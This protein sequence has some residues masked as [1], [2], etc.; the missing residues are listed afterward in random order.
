MSDALSTGADTRGALRRAWPLLRPFLSQ[1]VVAAAFGVAATVAALLGPQALRIAIDDGILAGDRHTLR[2]GAFA[3]LLLAILAELCKWVFAILGSRAGERVLQALRIRV[4]SRLLGQPLRF[5]ESHGSGELLARNVNDVQLLTEFVRYTL[6]DVVNVLLLLSLGVFTLLL[7]AP[8]LAVVSLLALPLPLVA[9]RWYGHVSSPLYAKIAEADAAVTQ[10]ISEG[11]NGVDVTHATGRHRWVLGRLQKPTEAYLRDAKAGV[12]VENRV[13]PILEF[14]NHAA[15]AV[16]LVAGGLLLARDLVTVGTVV[17]CLAYL[18]LV[19][20]PLTS[21]GSLVSSVQEARVAL[22]R[23][24][25][26]DELPPPSGGSRDVPAKGAL[27]V[28]DV[29]F[30]YDSRATVLSGVSLRAKPGQRVALAGRTGAGK[31]TLSRIMAGL[32]PPDEGH[33]LVG[34]IDVRDL[35]VRARRET[36]VLL[37]QGNHI[38]AGTIAENL[39]AAAREASDKDLEAAFA[40]LGLGDFLARLPDGLTTQVGRGGQLLSSGERQ[41]LG[42]VR[43]A[44]RDPAVIVLD[45]STSLVDPETEAVL[46]EPLARL[47][48]DCVLIIVAHRPSTLAA[49]DVVLHLKDGQISVAT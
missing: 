19:V 28:V 42:L 15:I 13:F 12:R 41:L 4:S 27:E 17:A 8:S 32:Y 36:V 30:G 5:F 35:T 1:L 43:V 7:T 31:T 37:P 21:I 23:L 25:S 10:R 18:R 3:F 20:E 14:N 46:R 2:S 9:L 26:I 47:T 33:V 16:V 40:R 38:F 6:A 44:L 22:A 24:L 48:R 29:R 34:G 39:R 45:E 11:L 49:A